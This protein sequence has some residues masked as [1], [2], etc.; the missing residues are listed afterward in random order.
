MDFPFS[1]I[2]WPL[3]KGCLKVHASC[4]FSQLLF[5]DSELLQ[6]DESS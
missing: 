1:D 3:S 4:Y 6:L 2:D 5:S